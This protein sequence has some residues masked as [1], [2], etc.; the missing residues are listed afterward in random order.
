MMR[1]RPLPA[2]LARL[3]ERFEQPGADPLPGHLHQAQRGSPRP[4]WCLVRSR[5]R[6]SSRRRSTSSRLLSSTMSM[7]SITMMPPIV[8]Q[9]ELAD[10]L[11]GGLQVVPGHRLFEVAA[12]P[13][14]LPGVDVDDRHGLG[15][16]DHKLEPPLGSHTLRSSALASLLVDP[17]SG[18]RRPQAQTSGSAGRP[19]AARR[20]GRTRAP[21]PSPHRRPRP[22]RRS[23]R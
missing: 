10:D 16:I 12:L 15:V 3:G 23:P 11:L 6:H 4:P 19:D 13:G 9:P 18:R 21:G 20:T 5:P 1:P 7:K 17:G 8:A 14:E 22:A 2:G